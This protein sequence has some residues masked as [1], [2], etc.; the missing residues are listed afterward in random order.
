MVEEL[1]TG[2]EE[3]DTNEIGETYGSRCKRFMEA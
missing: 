2:I 3:G 1:E